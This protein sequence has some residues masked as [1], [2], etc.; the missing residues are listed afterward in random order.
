MLYKFG[1]ATEIKPIKGK[2]PD[3]LFQTALNIVK[4]LDD[5]YGIERD[6]DGEDG[7]YVLILQ[8]VQGITEA[9]DLDIQ[10]GEDIHEHVNL[11]KCADGDYVN[12]LYLANNE[13]GIN[14]FLPKDIAPQILLDDLEDDNG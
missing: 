10:L 8:N 5:N 6:V 13:F 3:V 1:T 11:I 4:A 2:I 7:G 12:V 9:A 14:V